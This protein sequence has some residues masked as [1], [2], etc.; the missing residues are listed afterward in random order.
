MWA[1]IKS[2]P[3]RL[4]AVASALVALV[5]AFVPA[6]PTVAVLG[7]I[8]A[9]LGV[10]EVTRASVTPNAKATANELRAFTAGLDHKLP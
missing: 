4:Y 5:A 1:A 7:V 3:V 6:L 2:N 9:L 10:G 8:A